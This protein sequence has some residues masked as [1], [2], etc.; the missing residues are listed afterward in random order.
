MFSYMK[1][2]V[3]Q[4]HKIFKITKFSK[5]SEILEK[6]FLHQTVSGLAINTNS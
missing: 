5:I 3:Y 2:C 1:F 4:I 6:H